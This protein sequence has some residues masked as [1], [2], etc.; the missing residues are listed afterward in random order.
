M[1]VLRLRLAN[2]R[3]Y[4]DLE[5]DLPEGVTALLGPNGAGKSSLL[6]ALGFALFGP[7][8]SRTGKQLLRHEGAAPADPVQVELRLELGGQAI[9]ILREL[10]GKALLPQ[11]T[12]EVDGMVTVPP[13]AGS[14]EAATT[15]L[16]R[17]LG[18]DKDAFFTTVVARQGE[19]SRLADAT[20][21]ER[22]RLLLRML[23]IDQVDAAIERARQSRRDAEVQLEALRSVLP[24]EAELQ[25]QAGVAAAALAHARAENQGGMA[26]L[27]E[28]AGRLAAGRASLE[29]ARSVA[30]AH[31]TAVAALRH[32]ESAQM[33]AA[34]GARAAEAQLD[35]ARQ[36]A[37]AALS[38]GPTQERLAAAED[39]RRLALAHEEV[40]RRHGEGV[41]R[42][43]EQAQRLARL[44]KERDTL[45][46]S[47]EL[48]N[49]DAD[50]TAL[51]AAVQAL[52]G[53]VE[54]LG[55]Q[56]AVARSRQQELV[57]RLDHLGHVG[58]EAT[59]PTCEAPL[60]GRLEPLR[61]TS[62]QRL[63]ELAHH[64]GDLEPRAQ[65]KAQQAA[66]L[67]REQQRLAA[68]QAQRTRDSERSI[69]LG[70]QLAR[71]QALLAEMER[72]LPADPGPAP[73]LARLQREATEARRLHEGRLRAEALA[74]RLPALEAD[75]AKAKEDL[76]AAAAAHAQARA[77]VP[78]FDPASLAA[79]QAAAQA[80]EH[81][82]R[83][84]Q[85]HLQ[86]AAARLAHAEAL[87]AACQR[88]SE[89]AA[90]GRRREA[91]LAAE[92][93]EWGAVVGR[94]PGTGLLERFRDHLVGR[95]GPAISQ[96]AGRL[97]AGFTGGRYTELRLSEDY[98]VFVADGG[99]LYT[100]DRFSGGEQDLVHLSLRLA[101]SRL[102]A[103]RGGTEMRFLALDEVFGSLD[104]SRRDL[105]VASLQEL[106]GLYAQ[107][108]V[109]SHLEGLQDELG[110]A[111][112][113]G[114]DDAGDAVATV[115]GLS[116]HNG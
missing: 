11:A 71:E 109:I 6:E 96:E 68:V 8:A 2:F 116:L 74:T 75:A 32:A 64:I 112:L 27:E 61:A 104:R 58:S 28:A 66:A 78:P 3:R 97:L 59:C 72:S 101:V 7:T 79:A 92:A 107:V 24:P 65:S 25:Q 44:A 94:S 38:F 43:A 45:A 90:A 48:S 40:R 102:L 15:E 50:L 57:V 42:V 108:L 37:A 87:V 81:A 88:R 55:R 89:E 86:Q 67:R 10:R 16:E 70:H 21:A 62:Q 85:A 77:Q 36:A 46:A 91:H 95:V 53:E 26:R 69:H 76:D 4:R 83:S 30:A 29:A 51:E 52:H 9:R 60:G 47:L 106:G 84:A 111:I 18:M 1:R 17:R 103:E 31:A 115:A 20:P 99:T 23:G 54:D 39:A 113:V 41:Q 22:K 105:V 35:A 14:S 13:G 100:L 5:L 63:A 93:R 82:E 98:E 110:Q 34:Q 114:E 73:D 49:V 33:W 12:L 56:R 80:A 19:L